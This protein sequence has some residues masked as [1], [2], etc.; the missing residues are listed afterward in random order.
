M[1]GT[2]VDIENELTDIG[3]EVEMLSGGIEIY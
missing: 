3:G 2:F 1:R